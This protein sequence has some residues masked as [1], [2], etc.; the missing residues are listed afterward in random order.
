[1]YYID[2]ITGPITATNATLVVFS[3]VTINGNGTLAITAPTTTGANGEG[4]LALVSPNAITVKLGGTI[5]TKLTGAVYLPQRLLPGE[6]QHRVALCGD[7]REDHIR[8]MA[9]P[10]LETTTVAEYRAG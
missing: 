2:T 1:M 9:T 3:G 5:A 10:S 7:R 8:Q 6:R 4:G